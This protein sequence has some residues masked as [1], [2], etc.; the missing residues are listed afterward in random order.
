[1]WKGSMYPEMIFQRSWIITLVICIILFYVLL[2]AFAEYDTQKPRFD[3]EPLF[4]IKDFN[5]KVHTELINSFVYGLQQ[6]NNELPNDLIQLKHVIVHDKN[7]KYAQCD[8]IVYFKESEKQGG[9]THTV[10]STL[11]NRFSMS[12]DI[13]YK[14]Y[15]HVYVDNCIAYS[16]IISQ[17]EI[18]HAL[19]LIHDNDTISIMNDKKPTLS[20]MITQ[21]NVN[22][23]LKFYN[24]TT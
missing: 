23:V 1:M 22:D 16:E 20:I 18:G 7:F 21:Q 19:G 10:I 2:P 24:Y 11:S 8:V 5:Y 13:Y 9:F 6:W 4:C 17:H 14:S 12:I 15:C 3:H